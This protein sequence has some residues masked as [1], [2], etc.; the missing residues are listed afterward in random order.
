MDSGSE[1]D[2]SDREEVWKQ[3]FGVNREREFAGG[4]DPD[5]NFLREHRAKE[6]EGRKQHGA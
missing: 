3:I 5:S 6:M 2:D 1:A 4:D